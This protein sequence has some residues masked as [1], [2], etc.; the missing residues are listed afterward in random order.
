MRKD[1]EQKFEFALYLDEHIVCKRQFKILRYRNINEDIY[2]CKKMFSALVSKIQ[3]HLKSATSINLW[4]NYDSFK[5]PKINPIARNRD[6][7]NLFRLDLI[8][9]S[10]ILLTG[11]FEGNCYPPK[12]RYN[13]DVRPI[14]SEMIYIIKTHIEDNNTITASKSTEFRPR[15]ITKY[16]K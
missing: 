7:V 12:I 5:P 1:L 15:A 6:E 3:S 2:G 8:L 16:Q 9:N 4:S 11:Q 14:I 13:V 10:D